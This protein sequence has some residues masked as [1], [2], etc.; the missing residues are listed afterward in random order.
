MHSFIKGVAVEQVQYGVRAY[1]LCPGAIDTV[2]THKEIGPKEAVNSYDSPFRENDQEKV[3]QLFK[4]NK[5]PQTAS[6]TTSKIGENLT[7]SQKAIKRSIEKTT[8]NVKENLI[9]DQN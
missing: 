3:N 9:I 6:E 4:E 5:R 2:W 8:D 1:C 7:K